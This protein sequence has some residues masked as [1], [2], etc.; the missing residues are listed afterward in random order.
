MKLDENHN[1]KN[2][3]IKSEPHG[4]KS[5]KSEYI[6]YIENHL[7]MLKEIIELETLE[8]AWSSSSMRIYGVMRETRD[9]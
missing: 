4:E 2:I 6:P 7:R 3:K 9:K 8:K 5:S 1:L